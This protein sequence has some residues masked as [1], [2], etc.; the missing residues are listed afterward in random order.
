MRLPILDPHDRNI[1]YG[2]FLKCELYKLATWSRCLIRYIILSER[3]RPSWCYHYQ[4]KSHIKYLFIKRTKWTTKGVNPFIISLAF[5]YSFLHISTSSY[6][7]LSVLVVFKWINDLWKSFNYAI[8][9]K[10]NK[11][12]MYLLIL[13]TFVQKLKRFPISKVF[14]PIRMFYLVSFLIYLKLIRSI[15]SCSSFFHLT[16]CF[17]QIENW[18]I[19]MQNWKSMIILEVF[20][21]VKPYIVR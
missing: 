12:A 10:I 19:N 14:L 3:E 1:L 8:Q 4:N 16:R 17:I 7:W 18:S 2:I 5:F 9:F 6:C 11:I 13:L 21:P 20:F 15:V